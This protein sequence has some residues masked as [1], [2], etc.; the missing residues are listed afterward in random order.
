MKVVG[1]NFVSGKRLQSVS[2]REPQRH[3][4][5]LF[6]WLGRDVEVRRHSLPGCGRSVVECKV[7]AVLRNIFVLRLT[8]TD[9]KTLISIVAI[10]DVTQIGLDFTSKEKSVRR[11]KYGDGA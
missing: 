9:G 6:T 8:D 10:P 3:F 4:A 11:G 1:K 7:P 5:S 2:A